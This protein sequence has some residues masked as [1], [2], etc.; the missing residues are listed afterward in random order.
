MLSNSERSLH[1]QFE[2]KLS[3]A[4][5]TGKESVTTVLSLNIS[6]PY[7][8]AGT[9]GW[10]SAHPQKFRGDLSKLHDRIEGTRTRSF[11]PQFSALSIIYWEMRRAAT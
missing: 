9:L 5:R 8:L 7:K 6:C 11:A 1:Q 3:H 2:T 10:F 4:L